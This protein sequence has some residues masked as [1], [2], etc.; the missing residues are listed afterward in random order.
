MNSFFHFRLFC[1]FLILYF[2]F[3]VER[4]TLGQE[5]EA[6]APEPFEWDPNEE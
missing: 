5:E 6:A 2:I 3:L 1:F 4:M